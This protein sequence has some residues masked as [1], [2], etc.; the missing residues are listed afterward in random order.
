MYSTLVKGL[1]ESVL[2]NQNEWSCL[3]DRTS[4]PAGTKIA[5]YDSHQHA[6]Y[7]ACRY[8]GYDVYTELP[9]SKLDLIRDLVKNMKYNAWGTD[10]IKKDIVAKNIDLGFMWTG[11]FLYYYCEKIADIVMEAYDNGDVSSVEEI[12]EMINVLASDER[13][14]EVNGNKYQIGFDLFI[15]KDTI[16]FCDNLVI[17]KESANKELAYKF[18]NFMC[19]YQYKNKSDEELTPAFNNT[20]YVCYDTP[21]KDVYQDLVALASD[22]TFDDL[23]EEDYY[24]AIYDYAIGLCFDKYYPEDGQKGSI[25]AAFTRQY[26]KEIN[27][28]FNNARA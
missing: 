25:L 8:L 4:V 14:Y 21:Y 5:M 20:Y 22:E 7:A 26:I 2:S 28:A 15:P 18:I 1:E 24:D 11:D 9:K 27:T 23:D 19:S 13:I 3:F 12:I 6:Y 10:T 17:T 16:A